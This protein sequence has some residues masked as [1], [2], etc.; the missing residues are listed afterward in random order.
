[1]EQKV[2][3][4]LIGLL[5]LLGLF[6]F[7]F[8]QT[9]GQKQVVMR[10]NED[11]R[12]ENTSLDGKIKRMEVDLREYEGKIA[13]LNREL[14][15]TSKDNQDLTKKL[16]DAEKAKAEF[17]EK[18]KAKKPEPDASRSQQQPQT[19]QYL[20]QSGDNVYWAGVL[21]TKTDLEMQ[22]SKVTGELKD[23]KITAEQ[24]QREKSAFELQLTGVQRQ[25]DDLQR[26]LDYNQRMMDSIAQDL[27]RERNDKMQIQDSLK[28]I[29]NENKLLV[30]QLDG[31]NHKKVN[32]ERRLKESGEERDSAQKR[33]ENM[34]TMLSS[35]I[36]Q[37]NEF[38]EQISAI[39][40][41][42]EP[43]VPAAKP[44][45]EAGSVE[46]PAIVVRS[47]D[48][49]AAAAQTAS[50]AEEAKVVAVNPDNNFVVIDRGES[51]GVKMG[52]TF[53]VY[54]DGKFLATL[55][56]IQV[57]RDIAACDIKKQAVPLKIG[58]LI[59]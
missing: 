4:L 42:R 8:L 52:D 2:K 46:L 56:A 28:V 3:I 51:S 11:L 25:K 48:E 9:S 54:R 30:R 34:E 7:L 38:K 15:K 41:G 24:L 31:L 40:H 10:E 20:P 18:L 58:D 13:S 33:L 44:Q 6:A 12:R 37:I 17:M 35:K 47:Q 45:E 27:V 36:S 19:T 50:A 29:K 43:A 23:A 53:E 49:S 1:M 55:E 16:A 22:L 59:R 39:G 32:L 26:Q 21:K 5:V 14:D 57:R